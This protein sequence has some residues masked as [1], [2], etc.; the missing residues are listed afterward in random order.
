MPKGKDF[1]IK[2]EII[3][4]IEMGLLYEDLCTL[5][6]RLAGLVGV[7]GIKKYIHT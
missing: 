5:T 6:T 1:D 3:M 2:Y 4:S 7:S